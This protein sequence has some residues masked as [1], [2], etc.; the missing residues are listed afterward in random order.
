MNKNF[1]IPLSIIIV[2]T[3]IIVGVLIFSSNAKDSS[4]SI[5]TAQTNLRKVDLEIK[6]MFCIGCR[7]SVVNSVMGLPGVVQVDADP[8]TDS[9]WIIYNPAQ[10]TKEQLVAAAIFQSYPARILSDQKYIGKT[11]QGQIAQIPPEITQKLNLL[12]QKLQERGVG[13]EPFFQK[14]LDGAISGGYWDK[15]NNL[16]DNFLQV[17]EQN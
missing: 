13:L 9:G 8:R 4:V 1:F 2:G 6:N 12:A 3:L 17:Y 16:L 15:A 5:N 10:I 11:Q 14:E 7:S